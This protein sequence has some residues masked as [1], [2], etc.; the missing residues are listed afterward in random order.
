MLGR[1][2]MPLGLTDEEVAALAAQ[3]E[4]EDRLVA[5]VA[6]EVVREHLARRMHPEVAD[7]SARQITDQYVETL[8]RLVA[9]VA[10]EAVREHL[11]RRAHRAL[12]DASARRMIDR[13]AETLH[14]LSDA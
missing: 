13:Y 8:H 12:V 11:A 10:T 4:A 1:M 7:A 6:T 14:R 5:D 3:V 9:D 2:A